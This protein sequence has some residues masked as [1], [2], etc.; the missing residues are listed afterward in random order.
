MPEANSFTALKV[1]MATAPVLH[2]PDFEKQFVVTTDASDVVV[3]AILEQN[4]GSGLQPIAFASRKLNATEMRYSV[5]EREMLG[6]V[7]ALGQWK[8]YFQSPHPI[9]I[10]TD[11]APLRHLPNQTS[12]NSR[13]WRWIS[14]LQGYNV[15]I[16]HIPGK[17]NPADSLSRQLV[18]DALVRK[19]SVKDA[20][21]EYVMWLRV[22]ANATDEEIQS[23]LYQLFSQSVQ[24]PQGHNQCPQG[25]FKITNEGQAPSQDNFEVKPVVIAP[26]AVSKLQLN[27]SFRNS[28]YS[29][30][31]N[32]A[33]YDEVIVELESGKT[34]VVQNDDVYQRMTGIL[35]IAFASPRCR[36][37][38][39]ENS[40]SQ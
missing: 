32:E 1:A 28:L 17:K 33:P 3:G 13:V 5:Y 4:F 21:E 27:N 34:Q 9:I 22:A 16:R 31:R 29:L 8:H 15:E 6:I 26:T 23:A 40:C 14:I 35:A 36:I 18:S 10:Q 24:G 12:V 11:H 30:L 25:K 39:L 7:W 37:R 19:G 20:N 2:L 38:F